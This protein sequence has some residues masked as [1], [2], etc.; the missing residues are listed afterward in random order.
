MLGVSVKKPLTAP[1]K[2]PI[3][4]GTF[5][6]KSPCDFFKLIEKLVAREGRV[7]NEFYLDSIIYDAL[8]NGLNVKFF[9]VDH[10]LCW[11]VPND[12]K[13]FEYWQSCFHKWA[14]HQYNIEEDGRVP[15]HAVN[16]LKV[17]MGK[18]VPERPLAFNG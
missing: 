15:K 18:I 12:L 13:T 8:A 10:F 6:F 16:N 5:T 14:S 2:D 11:G 4:L 17:R 9:E 3:V 7:N 1:D